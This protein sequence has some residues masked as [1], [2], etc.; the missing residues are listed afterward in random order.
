V[1]QPGRRSRVGGG[2]DGRGA[3]PP[4]RRRW[5]G[6]PM[7]QH[8]GQTDTGQGRFGRAPIPRTTTPSTTTRVVRVGLPLDS[9]SLCPVC[10]T[11]QSAPATTTRPLLG[12]RPAD[13]RDRRRATTS[14]LRAGLVRIGVA[15]RPSRPISTQAR[16][17]A[18]PRTTTHA[19][20]R[21]L[22]DETA[23]HGAAI[24]RSPPRSSRTFPVAG[25]RL[26][27]ENAEH[28]TYRTGGGPKKNRRPITG[29]P[30]TDRI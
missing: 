3:R 21:R 28:R 17:L 10:P 27:T 16:V 24:L 20:D 15:G 7:S 25:N 2:W 1:D 19:P 13:G 11:V 4:D 12:G 9:L 23:G 30:C 26:T 5:G 22:P 18:G 6:S 14:A 29:G 8:R